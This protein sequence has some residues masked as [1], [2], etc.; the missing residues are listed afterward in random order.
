MVPTSMVSVTE[1]SAVAD[2]VPTG[3]VS[4]GSLA[5]E[6]P[7]P[8]PTTRNSTRSQLVLLS[9]EVRG[10]MTLSAGSTVAFPKGLAPERSHEP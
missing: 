6:P 8:C 10:F 1:D 9:E 5:A 3:W 7:H 4:A 2:I